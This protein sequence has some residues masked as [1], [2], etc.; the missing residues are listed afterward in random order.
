[1][2]L[3][4]SISIPVRKHAALILA[5]G[6]LTLI[7]GFVVGAL[8][9][10]GIDWRHAFRPAA[11][12][13]ASGQ[14]PYTVEP[15]YAAPWSLL[16]LVPLA[17][18]PEAAGRGLLFILSLMTLMLVAHRMGANPITLVAF[19]LSPPVIH[20][21][22]NANIDGLAMLGFILPPQIG[23]LFV[24]IK[25]Q[26]GIGLAVFWAVQ[27][28]QKG[29]LRCLL[30]TFAPV[31][32]VTAA[33]IVLFGPWPLRFQELPL[34]SQAFNASLWPST[35][36]IGLA[37]LAASI[38]RK[39]SRFAIAASP[40]FSPHVM[41]HSYAGALSTLLPATFEFCAAVIGLWGLTFIRAAMGGL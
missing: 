40:C 27:A 30:E 36:P 14:S 22:L 7:L 15:F 25:P 8:L 1:V 38:R 9:P 23:L 21:L 41:F 28:W 29:G 10:P 35:L 3:F 32:L 31:A 37:L 26:V 12:A 4:S 13:L 20:G 6:L 34:R 11:L 19:L 17:L 2:S 18:L 16:P 24:L 5:A 33:S 39:Q